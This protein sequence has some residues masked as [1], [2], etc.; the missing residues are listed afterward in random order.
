MGPPPG[1]WIV[2]SELTG[3]P[4]SPPLGAITGCQSFRHAEFV[5]MNRPFFSADSEYRVMPDWLTST[6]VP[7]DEFW[8]VW[9]GPLPWLV[10]LVW[11]LPLD[12]DPP[13]AAARTTVA[14]MA[15]AILRAPI[16]MRIFVSFLSE[17]DALY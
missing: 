16:W 10:A 11:P 4:W 1:R 12:D 7:S 6:D 15:A 9:M 14:T 3:S 2:P 8:A 17:L 5:Q 13:H